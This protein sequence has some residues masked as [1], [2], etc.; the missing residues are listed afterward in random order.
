MGAC[1]Q[2]QPAKVVDLNEMRERHQ[3]QQRIVRLAPELDGL[4]MIYEV[5]SDPD[6]LYAM[7]VLGWALKS[8]GEVMGVVPWLESL[9]GCHSLDD[10]DY[11]RFIGYRDP[12]IDDVFD[13]PPEHKRFELE[14]AAAYF[15]YEPSPEKTLLQHLPDTH[16]TYA[17]CIDEEDAPW[18]LKQ[19]HGWQLYSD[20][21]IE[22]LLVDEDAVCQT[23]ILAGD[24]CLY[25][26]R[27][28]HR[29]V[30][31]FQRAIANRIKEQDPDT[32]NALALMVDSEA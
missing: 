1:I 4:E 17:L 3:A 10:P 25:P 20:G 31:F 18:Q 23:P 32:L 8:N 11:G 26:G 12:E 14:H 5:A 22:A 7:P 16:G 15:D 19:I 21:S 9:V 24:D 27:S 6:S 13:V 28:R 2:Q 30:Y 29:L